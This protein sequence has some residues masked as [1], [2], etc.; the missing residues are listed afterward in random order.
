GTPGMV[1]CES[2]RPKKA[3]TA[4]RGR[5]SGRSGMPPGNP[6]RRR[7]RRQIK[8]LAAV[9]TLAALSSFAR[10][11]EVWRWTDAGG[12]LHYSNR[13]AGTPPDATPV[14]T[15]LIVETDRLPGAPMI[16]AG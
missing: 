6:E 8:T 10:A 14:T 4:G 15:R 1:P 13:P 5:G 9:L 16:A 2:A 12:T 3:W 7:R 11:E